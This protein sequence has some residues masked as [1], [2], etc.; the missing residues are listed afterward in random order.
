MSFFLLLS[1]DRIQTAWI[2]KGFF[3]Y[4]AHFDVTISFSMLI[5]AVFGILFSLAHCCTY[6]I[7]ITQI[8]RM[9]Y[10]RF[11][12]FQRIQ[13][14]TCAHHA[15]W[16]SAC[17]CVCVCVCAWCREPWSIKHIAPMSHWQSEQ[18]AKHKWVFQ[19]DRENTKKKPFNSIIETHVWSNCFGFVSKKFE[20]AIALTKATI[21]TATMD[22]V[23]KYWCK[24][25]FMYY[26]RGTMCIYI[27]ISIGHIAFKHDFTKE[28]KKK[29]T[30]ACIEVFERNSDTVMIVRTKYTMM[31]S[32]LFSSFFFNVCIYF[33]VWLF[34]FSHS[35]SSHV[36]VSLLLMPAHS[37]CDKEY[38]D[39]AVATT[40][41]FRIGENSTKRKNICISVY[42]IKRHVYWDIGSDN[43]QTCTCLRK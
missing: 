23:S 3:F 32:R 22:C 41:R 31:N 37:N 16:L 39:V 29:A 5:P 9:I 6:C 13:T 12:S 7:P 34:F 38:L 4:F 35:L 18:F 2:I 21:T 1:Q 8:M 19:S 42:M 24:Q 36:L 15:E 33:V 11:S 14:E 17:R 43:C 30:R 20:H 10:C 28:T 27:L 26:E 40:H 25:W